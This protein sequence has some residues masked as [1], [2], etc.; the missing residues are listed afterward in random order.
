VRVMSVFLMLF[1]LLLF[2]YSLRVAFGRLSW[3]GC[4]G[5]RV[6]VKGGCEGERGIESGSIDW[7]IR[8]QANAW[9]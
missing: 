7:Y 8:L 2:Y 9:A 5:S 4:V 6:V 3:V 1:S